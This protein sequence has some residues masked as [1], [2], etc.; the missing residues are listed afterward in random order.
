MMVTIIKYYIVYSIYT[1]CIYSTTDNQNCVC[2]CVVYND[3]C[4]G[5]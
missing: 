1:K 3:V 5:C 4:C 2:V